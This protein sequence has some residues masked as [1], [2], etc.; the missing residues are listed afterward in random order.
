MAAST[1]NCDIPSSSSIEARQ[2]LDVW[3][4]DCF[5][6]CNRMLQAAPDSILSAVLIPHSFMRLPH[7]NSHPPE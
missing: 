3:L 5:G 7:K 2:F 1:P 6:G 4:S